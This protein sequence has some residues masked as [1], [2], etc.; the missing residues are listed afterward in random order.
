MRSVRLF[1]LPS[2][3]RVSPPAVVELIPPPPRALPKV[4]PSRQPGRVTTKP[5]VPPL[6]APIAP[7]T[8]PST[9]AAPIAAP[10]AR[11]VQRDSVAG[12]AADAPVNRRPLTEIV[13]RAT[14][15]FPNAHTVTA[16][17][18]IAPA[19]VTA[20]NAPLSVAQRDSIMTLKMQMTDK[21][22][23]ESLRRPQ[24]EAEKKEL[25]MGQEPGRALPNS[26]AAPW[27]RV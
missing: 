13:P 12:G 9:I 22:A 3:E 7:L 4:E 5:T 11:V 27:G 20:H 24:T 1:P 23:L 14:P 17:A 15:V 6:V 2:I 21:L 19:G 18:A 26:R 10:V 8:I 25:A 16:P